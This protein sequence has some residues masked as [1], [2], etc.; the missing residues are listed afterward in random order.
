M[1]DSTH[2]Y[3]ALALG[4]SKS[5][6]I[7]RAAFIAKACTE[8]DTLK[9]KAELFDELVCGLEIISPLIAMD[10][11]DFPRGTKF[12]MIDPE[13]INALLSKAKALL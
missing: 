9:A 13:R 1:C 3:V 8:H 5:I 11:V 4:A 12:A 10:K 7:K 6:R 2:S